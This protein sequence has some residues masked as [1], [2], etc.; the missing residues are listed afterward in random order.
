MRNPWLYLGLIAIWLTQA[1]AQTSS[2]A[3]K[4]T[5]PAVV[6][7]LQRQED[8][9]WGIP[10]VKRPVWKVVIHHT[11][12]EER[13]VAEIRNGHLA[14]HFKDIAYHFCIFPNGHIEPGRNVQVEG[15]GVWGL[16]QG[17]VEIVL[18][19]KLHQHPPTSRQLRA[20]VDFTSRWCLR[21]HVPV[22]LV[23]G[24]GETTAPGRHT[25]CPGMDMHRFRRLVEQ[26]IKELR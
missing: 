14:R 19:G 25:L 9:N 13:S 10:T 3:P 22:K 6:P 12:G 4:T 16:H 7:V 15:A 23:V 1:Q 17:M 20:A 24:H 8:R 2:V 21:Y 5:E 11:A 26:W 18:V